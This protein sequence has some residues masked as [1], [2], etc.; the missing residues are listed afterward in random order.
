MLV[1]APLGFGQSTPAHT[2]WQKFPAPPPVTVTPPAP[3]PVPPPALPGA[4][5][6]GSRVV[7]F[8]KP[9]GE[10]RPVQ[11]TDPVK[12][13]EKE[14]PQDKPADK[15]KSPPLVSPARR[16]EPLRLRSNEELADEII[17]DVNRSQQELYEYQMEEFRAGKRTDRPNPVE[18]KK[19][20][21]LQRLPAPA[22]QPHVQVKAGYDPARALLEPGYVV[23]RR[24]YFEEKNSERYGWELGLAQPLVSAAVF[25][26]DTLLWP[27]HLASNLF[28]R[29][30]TSAGKCRPGDPV[31]YYLYPPNIT[32]GGGLIGAGVFI[33][34][35]FLIP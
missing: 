21:D 20:Q 18:P 35:G 7:V 31:A 29:Y 19:P 23:H 2:S 12:K 14:L 24:L 8:T 32:L 5:V 15:D 28:E 17:T 27:S 3:S 1:L 9:A 10:I 33:G 11:A 6:P 16:S 25:A 22:F 34:T 13:P 30:D 26:K 4:S